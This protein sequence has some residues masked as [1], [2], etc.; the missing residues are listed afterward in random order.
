MRMPLYRSMEREINLK[1]FTAYRSVLMGVAIIFIMASHSLGRFALYG[2]IGVEWFLIVS[3]IGQFYSL[4][5]D[6]NT[7][8]YY[9]K[10]LIRLLPAYLV[11]AIPFF[12]IKYPFS[13][14][15]FIIRITGLNLYFFWERTF[16]FVSLILICYL[17][18]PLYFKLVKKFRYSFIVP[19][20]LVAITFILSFHMPR[21]QILITRIP[22]F[23]LGMNLGKWVYEG[24]IVEGRQSVF[25]CF[26]ASVIAM[27][28]VVL[29]NYVDVTVEIERL[30]Y[31]FCGIP[32]LFLSLSI[33][34]Q[35][36]W[37]DGP[38]AFIGSVSYEIYLLHESIVLAL[39]LMLPLPKVI[40]V[41]ISYALA[42]SLAYLL[43]LAI[44]KLVAS[45]RSDLNN[46]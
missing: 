38:L 8:R 31:F 9:G 22:I 43:H 42:I 33:V 40:S 24:R 1:D 37:I 30:V 13:V 20:I 15:D 25:L 36:S 7:G 4:S 14:K 21:T 28:M 45:P 39:C 3:A 12:L 5:K 29:V 6:N 41:F 16:W 18:S 26:A 10:R 23:L 2:N 44:S 11:V 17:I 19:F 46:K 34:K 27:I 35:I 32:S